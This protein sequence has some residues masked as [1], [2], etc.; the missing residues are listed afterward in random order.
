[1]SYRIIIEEIV[2]N[3]DPEKAMDSY[4]DQRKSIYEQTAENQIDLKGIIDA[5]NK[6][7][8]SNEVIA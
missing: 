5:F 6:Q 8:E 3:R 2:P 1:M 4:H 7:P